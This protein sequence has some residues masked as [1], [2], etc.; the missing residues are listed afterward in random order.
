[1]CTL[2]HRTLIV[3]ALVWVAGCSQSSRPAEEGPAGR[4]AEAKGGLRVGAAAT[5]LIADDSMVIGGGIGPGKVAGQEGKLRAV[6]IVMEKPGAGKVA[7]VACDVLALTRDLLDPV[8]VEIA[9]L[10]GI[11]AECVLISA[12]HTHHAPTT[13]TVHGY[14]REEGFC[15][16]VQQRIVQ[17]VQEAHARL[18]VDAN[19]RLHFWLGEES[20]VGQNSR[21]L[22]RDNTIYWVGPREDA[23]RPTGP[24][25][26]EL[27][28]LVF[29]DAEGRPKA[30]VFNHSTHTIGSRKGG[31]S[32]AF[33]GLAAQE[34]E[35]ELGG[36]VCFL[37]G[38]SGSTHNLTV[39]PDEAALRIKEAVREALQYAR[40]R[41]V[42][43]LAAIKRP[44]SYRVRRFDEAKEDAAVT[45]YC[46]RRVSQAADEIIDVF[47]RQRAILARHQGEQR[48]T[49]VQ[50]IRIGD[51]A[52]VGIPGELFTRL[53]QQIKRQSP[54]RYTCV[55]ELANDWIG[56]LPDGRAFEYGGY[57]VWT[58]LHSF[59][60]P[61]TGEAIVEQA[62][63]LLHELAGQA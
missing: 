48:T 10:S 23:V 13:V 63:R 38:A 32:P 57:Q 59:V 47:R 29:R 18:P 3:G 56:Y 61:G 39:P 36:T 31:R 53:G 62:L 20:S 5:E 15:R 42:N 37:E 17:A 1:M 2:L 55:V 19:D 27:P 60:E 52:I 7:V 24:F 9:R 12:T 26:P 6:A 33:Y 51:V 28:V 11:P 8:T 35:A 22:L 41:P 44:F 40:H 21:L 16:Q 45:A 4:A 46:R 14:Q 58:G 50:A 30:V 43:R 54:F 34:L 25:D 49:W